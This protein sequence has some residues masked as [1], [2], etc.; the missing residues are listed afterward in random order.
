MTWLQIESKMAILTKVE[1]AWSKLSSI[2]ANAEDNAND[3]PLRNV[4]NL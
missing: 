4:Q 2:P 3:S 1:E